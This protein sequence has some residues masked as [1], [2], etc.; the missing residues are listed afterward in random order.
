MSTKLQVV[1]S[2]VFGDV[3]FVKIIFND[4]GQKFPFSQSKQNSLSEK[5]IFGQFGVLFLNV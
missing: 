5:L 3:Y 4:H 1:F 2:L